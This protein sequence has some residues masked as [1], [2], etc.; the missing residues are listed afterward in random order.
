LG[1]VVLNLMPCVFPVLSLKALHL[2]R[3]SQDTAPEIRRHGW[4][5]V[6]GVLASFGL[7]GG[8]LIALKA[9]GAAVGWGFQ[10][11]SPLFVLVVAYL[12]FAAGLSLSGVFSIGGSLAGWGTSLAARQDYIGSFFTGALATL[13]AV[14][15]TGPL[16]GAAVGFAVTQPPAI[17]LAVLWALGL[18]LA[19]PVLLLTHWPFLRG[20]LPRP[21]AWMDTV[22]Q[23]LAFPMYATTV[24][25]VWVLA[26]QGGITLVVTALGGMVAI[27]FGA[28]IFE[29]SRLADD[30]TRRLGSGAAALALFAALLTGY[31]GIDTAPAASGTETVRASEAFSPERLQTLRTG[32]HPVFLNFTAAWCISCL[33]NEKV[34]LSSDRVSLAFRNAGITYLKG[35]WTNRDSRITAKLAE[36]GRSGVPLYVYYPAGQD[37]EPVILPQILTP[38]IVLA[39]LTPT[40]VSPSSLFSLKE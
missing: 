21:G 39:A 40:T 37:S 11:Q 1:G 32:G 34:A 18:G 35:D 2:L 36:F 33:V 15:C 23:V 20:R 4:A 24:W 14:P 9:G 25:L 6:L 26:Q 28:W 38:D 8:V 30:W 17:L 19:L 22:K 27:A 13:V 3:Q 31:L 7:L 29:H 10:F 12:M 16:M 5:Y